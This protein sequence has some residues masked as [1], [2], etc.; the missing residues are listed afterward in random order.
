[1]KKI[2]KFFL[3]FFIFFCLKA[4]AFAVYQATSVLGQSSFTTK[5]SATTQAGMNGPLGVA[6]DSTTGYLFVADTSNNRV[7]VYDISD[8]VTNG[9]NAIYV[10]GQENFTSNT[11]STQRDGLTGP[12]GLVVDEVGRRLFV[13]DTSKDRIV[14]Y[15]ITTIEN[16]EDAVSFL[17]V[18]SGGDVTNPVTSEPFPSSVLTQNG[19]NGPQGLYYDS[20]NDYLYVSDLGNWRVMVF[21]VASITDG[22]NAIYVL[23]NN[24]FVTKETDDDPDLPNNLLYGPYDVYLDTERDYLYVMDS[25]YITVFDLSDGITNGE[26]ILYRIVAETDPF[27]GFNIVYGFGYDPIRQVLHNQ[28]AG[29]G[30]VSFDF[31]SISNSMAPFSLIGQTTWDGF[32]GFVNAT[33]STFA[34]GGN[35]EYIESLDQW[36]VPDTANNRVLF[37][38]FIDITEGTTLTSGSVG[39]AYTNE[40]STDDVQGSVSLSLVSGTL[41]PGLSL[42]EDDITG[43]PT[44]AGS[45]SFTLRATDVAVE[46]VQQQYSEKAFTLE[47]AEAGAGGGGD[48]SSQNISGTIG[49]SLVINRD[50]PITFSNNVTVNL[51]TAFVHTH[52]ELSGSKN[53]FN[54]ERKELTDTFMSVPW[55]ICQGKKDCESGFYDVFGN[56]Y[57]NEKFI[58][59]DSDLIYYKKCPHFTKYIGR[60]RIN[61]SSEVKKVKEFLN[62]YEGENLNNS[63]YFDKELDAA[64][65]RFQE[66]Y[67]DEIL[68]PWEKLEEPTGYWYKTTSSWANHLFGCPTPNLYLEGVDKTFK[69]PDGEFN[70][71]GGP[72]LALFEEKNNIQRQSNLALAINQ[73][74]KPVTYGII[75]AILISFLSLY[76]IL[77]KND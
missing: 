21:D 35:G 3:I 65:R 23:G 58:R 75:F 12:V 42:S 49:P 24:D 38:D 39:E 13:S 51:R 19:V 1:M 29:Q 10:L 8:G 77:S 55:D 2:A 4:D 28:E 76:L 43:T 73:V 66:K 56:F 60:G 68:N 15:D 22:E 47:I 57:F 14:V 32:D 20:E 18:F 11:A 53:F 72:E 62:L 33:Q 74:P 54:A 6:Y 26:N 71:D 40:I 61:S 16:G 37:F 59:Q 69:H 36:I 45:Y 70:L 7:L 41:P 63:G 34:G 46:G 67:K 44:T 17:G 50:E 5:S 64:V 25:V 27:L 9:E 52:Y 31:S 30:I 48:D